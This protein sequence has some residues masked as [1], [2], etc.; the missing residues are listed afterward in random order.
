QARVVNENV[1]LCDLFATLCD[2]T[3]LD[4]PDGLDSRS[5]L[6]LLHGKTADWK[7][8]T[9][10]QINTTHVM[11]KQDQLKYQ[12]YGAEI[13]EVLFDLADD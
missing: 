7:N 12:Y 9:V 4:I 6:P 11:I 10:S 5:L 2:L 8:E 1:N 13:P 3:G